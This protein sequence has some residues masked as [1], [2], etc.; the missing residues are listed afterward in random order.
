MP[1]RTMQAPYKSQRTLIAVILVAAALLIAAVLW[2]YRQRVKNIEK[3]LA[4]PVSFQ[5]YTLPDRSHSLLQTI[6][7]LKTY[8]Q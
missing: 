4:S 8:L 1:F 6:F 2:V 3:N 5:S 7:F